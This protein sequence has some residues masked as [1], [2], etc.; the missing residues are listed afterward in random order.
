M[1]KQSVYRRILFLVSLLVGTVIIA[2]LLYY[3]IEGIPLFNSLYM[4]LITLSTVGFAEVAELSTAGRLITIC[5]ILSGITIV[6]YSASS[7]LKMIIEGELQQTF[8]RNRVERS[9]SKLSNHYIVCGYGRIGGLIAEEL[10]KNNMSSVIIERDERLLEKLK[11]DGWL[12]VPGDATDEEILQQ[13]GIQRAKG[14]VTA[15]QSDVDNVFIV[16]SARSIRPDIYILSRATEKNT[17][18]KLIKAGASKV[19]LPYFIGGRRMAQTLITPTV[20]DFIDITMLDSELGL[21]MGEALIYEKSHFAGKTLVSSN[22]RKEYGIIIVAIK[23]QDGTMQF[24]PTSDMLLEGNDVIVVLGKK[25]DLSRL[26]KACL[27]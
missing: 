7:L 16:L 19:I 20:A 1:T 15:V 5:V 13:A 6:A 21:E 17:E 2:T 26:K 23:K 11:S 10:R 8:G 14:I 22:I 9:I 12:Y 4:T 27:V 25:K 24:N 18:Q 3:Y